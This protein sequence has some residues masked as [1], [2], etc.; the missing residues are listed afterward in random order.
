MP[1]ALIV[2]ALLL[3]AVA[4]AETKPAK[5]KTCTVFSEATLTSGAKVGVCAPTRD[6]GKPAYLRSYSVV[7]VMNPST[8]K[9]ERVMVGFP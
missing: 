5:P 4:S 1:K 2:L 6:G 7:S 9:A 8:G 3:P